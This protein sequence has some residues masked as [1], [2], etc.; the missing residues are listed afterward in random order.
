MNAISRHARERLRGRASILVDGTLAKQMIE[1]IVQGSVQ[2][3]RKG[4][5]DCVVYLMQI[6]KVMMDVVWD[7]KK[8]RV[9]TAWKSEGRR[10]A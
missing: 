3:L 2:F 10:S 5:G 6:G 9:V 4:D 7:Y 1:N 8:K